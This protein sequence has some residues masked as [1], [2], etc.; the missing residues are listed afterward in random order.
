MEERFLF[1]GIALHSRNV[2]PGNIESASVIEANLADAWLA[3][4]NRTAVAAGIATHAIAIHLFP[5]SG[6][7]FADAGISG[8]DV[9]QRGHGTILRL[10]AGVGHGKQVD[11]HRGHGETQGLSLQLAAVLGAVR[12]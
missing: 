7:G 12:C 1:D 8:E 4:G 11:H 10:F 5:E 3:F 6:V 2:A 9:V